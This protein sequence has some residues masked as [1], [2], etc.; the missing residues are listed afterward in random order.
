VPEQNDEVE[1]LNRILMYKIR[2]M[3]NQTKISR[4]MWSEIIKT[5][6]YL[7]NRRSHY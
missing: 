6:A 3:L 7:S 1:R 5:I 4:D 2:S